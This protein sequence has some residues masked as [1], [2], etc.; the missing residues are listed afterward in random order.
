MEWHNKKKDLLFATRDG[1]DFIVMSSRVDWLTLSIEI[2]SIA[3][4]LTFEIVK[5]SC[6]K[7]NQIY[8]CRISH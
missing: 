4:E 6:E 3:L 1:T 5:I 8:S 2:F 7:K